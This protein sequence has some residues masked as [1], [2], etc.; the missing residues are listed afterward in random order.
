MSSLV[1][2]AAHSS[3][4]PAENSFTRRT[5]GPY[6]LVFYTIAVENSMD[7]LC[8]EGILFAVRHEVNHYI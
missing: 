7:V 1:L 4:L 8:N 3:V 6:M 2:Y 5:V